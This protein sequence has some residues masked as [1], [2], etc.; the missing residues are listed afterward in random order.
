MAEQIPPGP[1]LR[2]F[3]V[4]L[5]N[6]VN[7][8]RSR[9]AI[10]PPTVDTSTSPEVSREV[11]DSPKPQL[12]AI[13]DSTTGT[14]RGEDENKSDVQF[15][16]TLLEDFKKAGLGAAPPSRAI[17][18]D[19]VRE[20]VT[21]QAEPSYVPD[22]FIEAQSLAIRLASERAYER[23][24]NWDAARKG[25]MRLM[26]RAKVLCTSIPP[27]ELNDFTAE[28]A[29]VSSVVD[30]CQFQVE[31]HLARYA[32]QLHREIHKDQLP[33]LALAIYHEGKN[34]GIMVNTLEGKV[35]KLVRHLEHLG[36]V[37]FDD[38]RGIYCA[39][40]KPVALAKTAD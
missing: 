17:F 23:E 37:Q 15:W 39:S 35:R 18:C 16:K 5:G 8:Y 24:K 10:R 12:V 27:Q 3:A 9:V 25:M 40:A 38:S 7:A 32:F 19:A 6:I 36:E 34:S 1:A 4:F 31:A 11:P 29:Q 21:A 33:D 14:S 13:S 2:V 28:R 26:I 20:A 30:D 22:L